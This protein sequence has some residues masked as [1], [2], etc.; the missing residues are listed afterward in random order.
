MVPVMMILRMWSTRVILAQEPSPGLPRR[1]TLI[2]IKRLRDPDWQSGG[3]Q[4]ED[5]R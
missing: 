3:I 5:A 1:R 4:P 2:N